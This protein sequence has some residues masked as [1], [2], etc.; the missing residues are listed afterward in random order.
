METI[1]LAPRGLSS[2]GE[3]GAQDSRPLSLES[4]SPGVYL[5]A[6]SQQTGQGPRD[7]P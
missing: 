2:F 7:L 6:D 4:L 3:C 5:K 1:P